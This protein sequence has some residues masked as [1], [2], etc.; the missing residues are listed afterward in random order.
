MSL[1]LV[2]QTNTFVCM[3]V[4]YVALL[5]LY[6]SNTWGAKTFP[7]M[8]TSIFDGNGKVYN[9]TFVFGSTFSLNETAYDII[10]QPYLTAA[11]VWNNMGQSW[12]VSGLSDPTSNTG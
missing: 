8:S 6:Y 12:A 7:F 1:P 5:G 4:G 2:Q 11:T 10:G 9:Q 3:A